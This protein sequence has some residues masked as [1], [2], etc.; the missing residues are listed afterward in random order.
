MRQNNPFTLIFGVKPPLIIERTVQF[1]QIVDT[2]L[3]EKPVT[4][5]YMITGVRGSG[6]TVLLADT[7]KYFN[8]LDDWIVV[9]LNP[10]RDMIESFAARLYQQANLK[11]KFSKKEFSFSFHRI[12]FSIEGERPVSDASSLLQEMLCYLYKKGKKIFVAI[13]EVSNTP[14]MKV[15]AQEYQMMI[16]GDLPVFLLMTG[17]YENIRS[18]QNESTLTFLYRLP[19]IQL[20]SL[21]MIDISQSFMKTLNIDL[22]FSNQL[23]K[24]TNGYA[25]AYQVLGYLCY[26]HEYKSLE[27][28]LINEYDK[29]LRTYVYDKIWLDLPK[30]EKEV[31]VAISK[32]KERTTKNIMEQLGMSKF[33]F[34]QYR[35]RLLK[36]GI[37]YNPNWGQLEFVLPRF[38][39]YISDIYY[40][41]QG[42]DNL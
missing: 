26:E 6:K 37:L 28:E 21:S 30:K 22:Q 27:E 35:D 10:E 18:L 9:E 38:S 5:A 12:T 31:L 19:T 15:F 11:Y 42:E 4:T 24:L 39:K 29:Y 34:S 8:N 7:I 41:E 23:A 14:Q 33:N 36:K 25:Y 1:N 2:F 20:D 32:L 40:F 16:R 3:S 13:D 17:L